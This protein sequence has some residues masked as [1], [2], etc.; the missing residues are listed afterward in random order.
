MDAGE[1]I[2]RI[3]NTQKI[4]IKIAEK[5]FWVTTVKIQDNSCTTTPFKQNRQN[6]H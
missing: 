3:K 4:L 5:S 6:R 2:Q 1:D